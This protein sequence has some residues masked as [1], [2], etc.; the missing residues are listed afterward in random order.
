MPKRKAK[1]LTDKDFRDLLLA[2]LER[3]GSEEHPTIGEPCPKELLRGPNQHDKC[4]SVWVD[5]SFKTEDIRGAL[6]SFYN[7]RGNKVGAYVLNNSEAAENEDPL[8][9]FGTS[10]AMVVSFGLTSAIYLPADNVLESI[11]ALGVADLEYYG[12]NDKEISR[13]SKKPSMKWVTCLTGATKP[14]LLE[15]VTFTASSSLVLV[16]YSAVTNDSNNICPEEDKMV[17]VFNY[18]SDPAI[19]GKAILQRALVALSREEAKLHPDGKY[20]GE[21]AKWADV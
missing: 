2:R 6:I 16:P 12:D 20:H 4:V 18:T 1:K 9:T 15:R 21:R 14:T 10:I 13:L 3:I 7:G 11:Q 8:L 17:L 19:L 5:M